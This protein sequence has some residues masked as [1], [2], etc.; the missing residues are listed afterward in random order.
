MQNEALTLKY[1]PACFEEV[2]GQASAVVYL[3]SL[4]RRNKTARSVALAGCPGIGKTTLARIY[5]KAL[6]CEAPTSGGSPCN[7]CDTCIA[8]D[9]GHTDYYELNG[10]THGGIDA[11]R[12]IVEICRGMPLR[13]DWRVIVID[14]AQGLS[15]QAFDA[16]LKTLEEPPTQTVFVLAT[17]ERHRIRGAIQSRCTVLDLDLIDDETAKAYLAHLCRKEG[18]GFEDAALA[19]IVA[20]SKGQLRDLVKNLEQ[21]GEFDPTISLDVTLSVLGVAHGP[22]VVGFLDA[23]FVGDLRQQEAFLH[24]W[25]VGAETKF[26]ALLAAL[27]QIHDLEFADPPLERLADPA[28]V[29]IEA[30]AWRRLADAIRDRAARHALHPVAVWQEMTDLCMNWRS[31]SELGLRNAA[32]RLTQMVNAPPP[33]RSAEPAPG[34]IARAEPTPHLGDPSRP[35]FIVPQVTPVIIDGVTRDDVLDLELQAESDPARHEDASGQ[36]L[37]VAMAQA[38]FEAASFLMQEHGLAFNARLSVAHDGFRQFDPG[39]AAAFRAHLLSELRERLEHWTAGRLDG[40]CLSIA[41]LERGFGAADG[42]VT[43]IAAHV[44]IALRDHLKEWLLFEFLPRFETPAR[45]L[46]FDARAPRDVQAETNEHWG[47]V[48]WLC[49]GLNP[50][51]LALDGPDPARAGY[52]CLADLLG[53]M[54]GQRRPAGDIGEAERIVVS[55]E[56]GPAAWSVA[57]AERL[58]PLSAFADRAWSFIDRGW[59]RDEHQHRCRLRAFNA[60][61]ILDSLSF[62]EPDPLEA[63]YRVQRRA[64]L[65]ESQRPLDPRRR[66]RSWSGWWAEARPNYIAV[67]STQPAFSKCSA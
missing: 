1:R 47:H 57:V 12:R 52:R 35:A 50:R 43:N 54:R 63:A 30:T 44:P 34:P 6:Q 24:L 62:H 55:P 15:R 5:A 41:V 18:F 33:V 32:L 53:T 56:I 19:T 26:D 25:P 40:R 3:S 48:R 39:S 64:E 46:F 31:G 7:A 21:V 38:V 11:I 17:T 27:L 60:A 14:E 59:E 22:I 13:A 61:D 28:F 42:L 23:V 45:S 37:S 36:Y 51:I 2:V 65:M 29:T 20:V 4:I 9:R 67:P 58:A 49:R 66:S 8:F 16:L 10:G